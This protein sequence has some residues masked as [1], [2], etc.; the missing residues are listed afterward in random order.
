MKVTELKYVRRF[1]LGDYEHEEFA[2]TAQVEDGENHVGL[3]IGL[4]ADVAAAHAGEASAA[5]SQSM[6]SG[7]LG[8]QTEEKPAAKGKKKSSK[9]SKTK[10]TTTPSDESE[11]EN[12]ETSNA[13]SDDE[14]MSNEDETSD[15]SE[16]DENE[17]EEQNE[18]KKPAKKAAGKKKFKSK[19][20]AYDRAN[21]IHKKLF[22]EQVKAIDPK[23][24]SSEAKKKRVQ[25]TSR[26]MH[27]EEMLDGEGKVL[28][29]FYGA[30][31][32]AITKK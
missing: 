23:W 32:K 16:S 4:K 13:Q 12:S 29:S 30:L 1:N 22:S 9:K 14:E 18:E 24:N 3:L 5:S 17:E 2:V 21:E 20:A 31:K 10:D 15:E 19:A 7:D 25:E 6:P 8:A 11:E 26:K 27:G 28:N